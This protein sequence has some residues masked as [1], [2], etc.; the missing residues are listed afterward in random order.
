VST[1]SDARE[2][3]DA[4]SDSEQ[5]APQPDATLAA[6]LRRFVRAVR[7][8]DEAMVEETVLRLSRSRRVL[9]PLAFVVGGFAMLFNGL[10]LLFSNWRLTLVQVLPAM[11]IWLAMLDLK[12][13]VLHGK[14]FHVLRGPVL[15]P[16]VLV[17]AAVTAASFFRLLHVLSG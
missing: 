17:I 14:S 1:D 5:P 4:S 10:T 8:G 16:I 6:R 7:D 12:A 13:H 2:S 3:G 11:W 15:I 9:T